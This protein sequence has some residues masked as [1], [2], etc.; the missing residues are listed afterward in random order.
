MTLKTKWIVTAGLP[1][2]ALW[3]VHVQGLTDK[4][5]EDNKNIEKIY[6]CDV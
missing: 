1:L 5:N 4:E 6:D 3:H 2:L